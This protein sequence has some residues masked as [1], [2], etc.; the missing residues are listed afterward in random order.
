MEKTLQQLVEIQRVQNQQ[1]QSLIQKVGE[2]GNN[3]NEGSFI[4][5]ETGRSEILRK[6]KKSGEIELYE[7]EDAFEADEEKE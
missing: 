1:L 7:V 2:R 3:T 5:Q 4:N 6:T